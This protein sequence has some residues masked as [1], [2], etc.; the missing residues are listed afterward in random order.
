VTLVNNL[1]ETFERGCARFIMKKGTYT[2]TGG[3]ILDAYDAD[4]ASKTIVLVRLNI[5][6]N[7]T[8]TVNVISTLRK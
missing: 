4:D 6:A 8:N 5:P 3:A 2:A 1:P 7:T